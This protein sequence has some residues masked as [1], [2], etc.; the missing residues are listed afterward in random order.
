METTSI[1]QDEQIELT[2]PA[3]GLEIIREVLLPELLG[4][5][6][7]EL[8]YWAGKRLARKYPYT[9]IEEITMFFEKAGWGTLT[10]LKQSKTTMEFELTGELIKERIRNNRHSSFQLEAGFLAEQIQT[11]KQV[12]T[13]TFEHP[14]K[15]A[16]KVH[17]TVKSDVKDPS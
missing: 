11:Q 12:I 9:S 2:V 7:P 6:T 1:K 10:L 14:K 3:F 17:F 8:L 15:R 16:G 13:E 5:D 4:Q